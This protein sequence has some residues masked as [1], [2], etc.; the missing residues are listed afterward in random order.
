[1]TREKVKQLIDYSKDLGLV[2]SILFMENG[3]QQEKYINL[4][5]PALVD[6]FVDDN[7][8]LTFY[9]KFDNRWVTINIAKIVYIV[10]HEK[11]I[12]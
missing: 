4:K 12:F 11:V 9:D 7:D 8:N 6:T 2:L 3:V 1:M 10:I 5:D